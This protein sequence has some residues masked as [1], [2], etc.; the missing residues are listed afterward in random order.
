M[1]VYAFH[2]RGRHVC[3]IFLLKEIMY[4]HYQ[5]WSSQNHIMEPFRM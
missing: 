2:G 1:H 3:I 4:V 5:G